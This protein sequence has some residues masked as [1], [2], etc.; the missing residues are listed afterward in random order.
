[1]EL[2]PIGVIHS[3][4]H[5]REQAP[6][7]GSGREKICE[8]EIFEE[9][10]EGFKDIQNFSHLILIYW[11]HKSQRF[12][13]VARGRGVFSTRSP[14]RPCPLG[15]CVV[16]LIALERNFLKIKGLDAINGTPLLDIKPYMPSIDIKR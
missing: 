7:Q 9:F 11:F 1:M 12:S 8:V 6:R 15:I 13:L 14:D 3:P 10:I 4:Y 16:E 2:N 5:S